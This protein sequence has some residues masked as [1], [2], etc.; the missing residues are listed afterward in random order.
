M[1][2]QSNQLVTPPSPS[3]ICPICQEIFLEPSITSACFHS[4]CKTCISKA[5]SVEPSCPL[6][7]K[8]LKEEDVHLNLALQ[9]LIAELIC[10]CPLKNEGCE[11]SMRFESVENHV[12][13]DCLYIKKRCEYQKYGCTFSDIGKTLAAHLE[14]CEYHKLRSF[15]KSTDQRILY[16][17][18]LVMDQ[19]QKL[20][21][22]MDRKGNIVSNTSSEVGSSSGSQEYRV[23]QHNWL[24][25]GMN[26]VKTITSERS[27]LTSLA[28]R[29]SG[30]ILAGSYDGSI[31]V[32]DSYSCSL[33]K[34]LQGHRLSVWSM[35]IDEYQ[36][37][38]YSGSSDE[39]INVWSLE[40]TE[41]KNERIEPSASF[42]SN[43]GKVYSLAAKDERLFSASSN[44]TINVWNMQN[45]EN[46]ATL[47]GHTA[48]VNSIKF[49]GDYLYSASSDKTLKVYTHLELTDS[50]YYLDLGP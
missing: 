40:N 23:A 2:L 45:L 32:F 22:L 16:L 38:L 18:S 48:G 27:G 31:K 33:R 42:G 26:C 9:G 25:N 8:K 17:E 43:Q 5:I 13:R 49:F 12:K 1:R 34:T 39:V 24:E 10:Y 35:S 15:I 50:S 28:Y 46:V 4:F 11:T 14:V 19:Q 47:S 37:K 6:C 41:F 44:G 30:T 3:L 21:S 20:A 36:R 7:R 29:S